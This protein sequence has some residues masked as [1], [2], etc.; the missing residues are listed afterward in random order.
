VLKEGEERWASATEAIVAAQAKERLEHDVN[1]REL[2]EVTEERDL[3]REAK[4]QS[5][6]SP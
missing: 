6:P 3:Q 2:V 4:T 5:Q 1:I